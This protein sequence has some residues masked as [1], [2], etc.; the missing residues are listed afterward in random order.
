ML[1]KEG[2]NEE[3]EKNNIIYRWKNN[4]EKDN[5]ELFTIKKSTLNNDIFLYSEKNY[6]KDLTKNIN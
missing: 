5:R 4:L 3:K 2:I 1:K 6:I